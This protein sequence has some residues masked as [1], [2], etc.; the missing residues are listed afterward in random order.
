[1][2]AIIWVFLFALLIDGIKLLVESFAPYRQKE[3]SSNHSKISVVIPLYNK[4][5][6][7]REV[8]KSVVR[9]FPEENIFVVNDGSTDKSL[10]VAKK[11]A[12]NVHFISTLNQGKVRAI[13]TALDKIKTP[14]VLLLDADVI[15]P[16][17]FRCPT[18]LIKDSITAASFN[19]MPRF[20]PKKKLI[21]EFQSHEY[22]K[23]M[24][25]GRKFQDRTGSVHCISGAVGLFK[26]ERLREL[27]KKHTNKQ[28][29]Y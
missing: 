25:I 4:E 12:P 11:S 13:E 7:I 14:L 8:L 22:A 9:L 29:T 2:E 5:K 26:T 10:E 16:E 3:F 21:L 15:L 6:E 24:Q 19:V 28:K 17:N 27:S 1:V 20:S 18:S 23:S